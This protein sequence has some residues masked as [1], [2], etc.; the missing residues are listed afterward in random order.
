MP[1]LNDLIFSLPDGYYEIEEEN[2]VKK[3]DQVAHVVK[4]FCGKTDTHLNIYL[5]ELSWLKVSDDEIG[6]LKKFAGNVVIRKI[7]K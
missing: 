2:I 6:K 4:K 1:T 5:P 7:Q 3:D